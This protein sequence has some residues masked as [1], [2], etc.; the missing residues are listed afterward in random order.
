[1]VIAAN[2]D[3]YELHR[4]LTDD[5]GNTYEEYQVS[6]PFLVLLDHATDPHARAA[7]AAYAESCQADDPQLASELRQHIR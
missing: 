7:I 2:D 1:M 5:S 3:G 4:V 6:E